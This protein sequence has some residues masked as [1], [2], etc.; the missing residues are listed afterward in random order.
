LA[1]EARELVLFPHTGSTAELEA[2]LGVDLS[3]GPPRH[4]IVAEGVDT[5]RADDAARRVTS[6]RTMPPVL[7][8][9]QAAVGRLP[10]HRHG[11]PLVV[12]AGRLHPVKG[13]R[14][15]VD[16]FTED[17]LASAAN[18]V[19]IGGDPGG[20]AAVEGAE[21]TYIRQALRERPG[22]AERVILL[23]ARTNTEVALVLAAAHHGWG[24]L[25]GAN[26]AYA[27][28]SEKEEF[29]LAIVEAMAAGLPPVAPRA[30]GPATYIDHGV[31]GVL[32]DTTD[33][34]AL[35]GAITEALRL[36]ADPATARRARATVD[37]RY[38]LGRM[39]RDL[40]A[41]YRIASGARALCQP[42]T[43]EL[44]GVA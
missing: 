12:S 7:A 19:I 21:L 27:C 24:A 3:S 1:R 11:L 30:G 17:E 43:T 10:R 44:E 25:I 4:T 15:L 16:A 28:A 41:V 38:T 37:A 29:G 5:G 8:E 42:V 2:L 31:S 40:T 36:A 34:A 23:G 18:L 13:M 33:V 6:V 22:L 32:A 26:G 9:L 20:P 35:R 14:R 39:A